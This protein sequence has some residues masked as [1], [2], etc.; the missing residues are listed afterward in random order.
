MKFFKIIKKKLYRVITKKENFEYQGKKYFGTTKIIWFFKN[1][2]KPIY[3]YKKSLIDYK[4]LKSIIVNEA[5]IKY[6]YNL[7][8]LENTRSR[9]IKP[10][11]I[12][13]IEFWKNFVEDSKKKYKK[14]KS[15]NELENA[16]QNLTLD[17]AMNEIDEYFSLNEKNY[18]MEYLQKNFSGIHEIVTIE[19]PFQTDRRPL[20]EEFLFLKRD[21]LNYFTAYHYINLTITVNNKTS[22]DVSGFF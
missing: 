4:Y 5:Y 2:V 19:L 3:P 16:K 11:T 13:A 1:R 22:F 12:G 20:N 17:S 6:L 21:I 8:Q 14:L 18:L 9:V 7:S 15:L 10:T